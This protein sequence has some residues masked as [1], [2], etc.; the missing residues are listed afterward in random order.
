MPN[1]EY[2]VYVHISPSGKMY[3]GITKNDPLDRW[4]NGRGYRKQRYF[5]R[6][7]EK[8]GWDNFYHE[9]LYTGLTEQ[10]A[11]DIEME[12]IQLF[13][14]NDKRLGY[15]T[16]LGG[17]GCRGYDPPPDVRMKISVANKGK[18]RSAE[19]RHRISVAKLGTHP[20]DETRRNMSKNHAD[21]SGENNPMYG[22]NHSEETRRKMS[23]N[24]PKRPVSQFTPEGELVRVYSSTIAAERATG[25][26]HTNI[27]RCCSGRQIL[28]GGFTWRYTKEVEDECMISN[29]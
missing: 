7:I 15:N 29:L 11:K 26:S 25:I 3:I 20:S 12:L 24:R 27:G 23:E 18:V 6:A 14:S 5:F 16:T 28:A 1:G 4:K 19:S 13:T 10:E 9:T 8:Y 2:S 22:K 17:D 21:V